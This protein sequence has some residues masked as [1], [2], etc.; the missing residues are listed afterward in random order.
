MI[1]TSPDIMK[2]ETPA[3]ASSATARLITKKLSEVFNWK[4][5][6]TI[7]LPGDSVPGALNPILAGVLRN[8]ATDRIDWFFTDESSVIPNSHLSNYHL[9]MESLLGPLGI[10]QKRIHRI[11]TELGASEA[12]REYSRELTEFFSGFPDFD[13][14][15]LGLGP[16]GHT[17][18]LFPGSPALSIT[19]KAVAVTGKADRSPRQECIT[20]TLPV[21]N[22]GHTVI[23]FTDT[24]GKEPMIDRIM[25][26]ENT[27]QKREYPF[28]YVES[29]YSGVSWFIYGDNR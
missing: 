7:V 21:I 3:E 8:M 14:I 5:N 9:Q 16:D 22:A 4:K 11:R 17:A 10:E 29:M 19:G 1:T 25:N 12:S 28:E 23:F 18:G 27:A 13:I 2:F 15:L 20:L 24:E 6:A 26:K